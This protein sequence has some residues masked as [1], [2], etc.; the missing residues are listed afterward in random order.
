MERP[1]KRPLTRAALLLALC[2]GCTAPSPPPTPLEVAQTRVKSA[3]PAE[4]VQGLT[5]LGQ[6]GGTASGALGDIIKAAQDPNL[7]VKLAAINA[8]AQ[9]GQAK[10][11]ITTAGASLSAALKDNSAAVRAAAAEALSYAGQSAGPELIALLSDTTADVR[12][13]AADAMGRLKTVEGI[14]G[15]IGQLAD[16]S[17][18]V[19]RAAARAL[20][21]M[22]PAAKR[23][24]KDLAPLVRQDDTEASIWSRYAITQL[25]PNHKESL[26]GV[27]TL[28]QNP[29][30]SQALRDQAGEIIRGWLEGRRTELAPALI[31]V[32]KEASPEHEQELR[33]LAL[34]ISRVAGGDLKQVVPE[35]VRAATDPAHP[36]RAAALDALGALGEQAASATDTVKTALGD[37]DA[38]VRAAAARAYGALSSTGAAAKTLSLKLL[39]KSAPVRAAALDGLRRMGAV[40][41]DALP[42]VQAAL[43]DTAAGVRVAAAEALAALSEPGRAQALLSDLAPLLKDAST[44]V[45]AAA[46]RAYG[47]TASLLGDATA[48]ARVLAASVGDDAE[49]VTLAALDGLKAMGGKAKA[50][51]PQIEALMERGGD[52]AQS[53]LEK[54]WQAA[55]AAI[56][57]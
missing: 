10:V 47:Q 16:Q 6:A 21:R 52:A 22:G 55:K 23:A 32:L 28:L 17:A 33:W 36:I 45:R 25:D 26:I 40:A 39:D 18:E 51:M 42:D 29:N 48:A 35:L 1:L 50:V 49:A 5:W 53:A 11:S 13:A 43:K 2:V 15:L 37:A 46:A 3:D 27:I 34:Q 41:R 19:R 44:D 57:D 4:R 8:L 9:L 30:M 7:N 24:V 20:G 12:A 54:A 31:A 38:S 56:E 14:D